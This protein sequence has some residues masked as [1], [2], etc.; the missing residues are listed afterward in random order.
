[1]IV[2]L[3]LSHAILSFL[4]GEFISCD[5]SDS[6]EHTSEIILLVYSLARVTG[7]QANK[8]IDA[9]INVR[10]N[11]CVPKGYPLR[12]IRSSTQILI[13]ITRDQSRCTIRETRYSKRIVS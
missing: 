13:W 3:V 5:Y 7:A 1:M 11:Q 12:M 6:V 8:Q 9:I 2:G 10:S 4:L